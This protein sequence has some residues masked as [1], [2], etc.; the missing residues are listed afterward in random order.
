MILSL[1]LSGFF[2]LVELNCENLFDYTHDDGKQDTEYL[3]EA[4][5]HWNSYRYWHK[6]N[7]IAQELVS[8]S[9]EHI[10]DLIA[11]CEVENDSVLHDLTKRSLLRNA[12]YEYLMTSSPDQRGIDV[13]LL[14]SPFTFAPI[15]HNAIRVQPVVGMRP[16]RDV[17]YVCGETVSGDTLHVFV[18]HQPSRFGGEKYS[19]PFRM[20]VADRVCQS[21]DSIRV[22]SPEAK[23][24]I[25]GDFNDGADSPSMRLYAQHGLMNLTKEARGEHGVKGTY[26]YQGEW[27]SI[28]HI[29]ATTALSSRVDTTMIHT[30]LFLLEEEPRYGGYRPKRTYVG[31][32]YHSGYSDHLPLI[33]RF[34]F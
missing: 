24:L 16:T 27:E 34:T 14:Y 2:T 3:P 10:P 9:D 11:L 22:L 29:L 6:L 28:D 33:V 20:A 23:I 17:L 30:P 19:R 13:A 12:G 7:N 4:T 8:C 18:V 5:R 26:R 1:L 32:R 21:V 31:M 15:R 25:A